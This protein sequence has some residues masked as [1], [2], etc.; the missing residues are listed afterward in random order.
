MSD[1][2]DFLTG[3][4]MTYGYDA[5]TAPAGMRDVYAA[6][7][8]NPGTWYG[9]FLPIAVDP[10]RSWR[11][12]MPNMMREGLLGVA[13]LLS[14]TETGEV[15][16][17]GASALLTGGFTG[18]R[19]LAPRGAVATGGARSALPMDVASRDARAEALGFRRLPTTYHGTVD[20]IREFLRNPPART[21][22]GEAAKAAAV[23]TAENAAL[24]GEFAAMAS[25]ARGGATGS[26]QSILP[27]WA[28]ADRVANLRLDG[29][30]K[31][32]EIAATLRQAWDDGF[33]AVKMFN[34]TS[35][36]GLKHQTIW[37]FREPNQL[38]SPFA[39]FDPA[40]RDSAD[41]LASVAVPS[42]VVPGFDVPVEQPKQPVG[43]RVP[44]PPD[45]VY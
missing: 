23:W 9:D 8:R 40:K 33:D 3:R 17:R 2:M 38:R 16:A 45:E 43:L 36:G 22:F 19:A 35:P 31:D 39:A 11:L 1:P 30:E 5:N 12:A 10:D 15:T 28:R 29:L 32:R 44:L 7:A 24:A 21:T 27:L 25:Q 6:L 41:L 18:G 14:G 34:H 42:L 37:A 26:G 20:D 13:D 4:A